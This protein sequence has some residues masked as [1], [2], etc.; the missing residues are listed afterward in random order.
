MSTTPKFEAVFREARAALRQ[1]GLFDLV[2]EAHKT[3]G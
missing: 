1:A 2:L 3:L